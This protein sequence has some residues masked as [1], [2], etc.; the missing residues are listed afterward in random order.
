[1]LN[2]HPNAAENFNKKAQE[3]LSLVTRLPSKA[4]PNSGTFQPEYQTHKIDPVDIQ[5]VDRVLS[6]S[7]FGK[8]VGLQ[9]R[10]EHDWYGLS[11]ESYE[12]VANL[13]DSVLKASSI[14]AVA[15]Q[16][17]I[18]KIIGEWIE[19]RTSGRPDCPDFST[20]LLQTLNAKVEERQVLVPIAG[21]SIE[22]PFTVGKVELIP[23]TKEFM[24]SWLNS[25]VGVSSSPD[26]ACLFE[27]EMRQFQGYCAG[28]IVVVADPQKCDELAF[29]RV[30]EA[31]GILR[32]FTPHASHPLDYSPMAIWGT[33]EPPHWPRQVFVRG[34]PTTFSTSFVGTVPRPM[35]IDAAMQQKMLGVGLENLNAVLRGD[36][37][38][39]YYEKLLS[40]LLLFSEGSTRRV[41]ADKLVYLTVALESFFLRNENEP[42]Q[43]NLA[44]RMAFLLEEAAEE[45][46]SVV[47]LVKCGYAAR[48]AYVHHGRHP[49]REVSVR[50][51][52][53]MVWKVFLKL[54]MN[55]N[56]F[57]T[58]D[59]L[60]EWIDNRKFS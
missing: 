14:A 43:S 47:K 22:V 10:R 3:I 58:T 2:L 52:F 26:V 13:A 24:E 57:C 9:F 40:S 48:S 5:S 51:F 56:G 53:S 20:H 59:E 8:P 35:V 49:E 18:L 30:Q 33:A 34:L 4:R 7:Y 29:H 60:L 55:S 46:K 45:R 42:I 54:C 1:M 11:G 36:T 21:L 25:L 41:L 31:I 6:A 23:L 12:L 27:K 37:T 17:T 16:T 19:S 28:R 32:V 15:A 38:S 39:Q 50:E 44:E